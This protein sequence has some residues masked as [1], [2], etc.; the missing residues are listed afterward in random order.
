[1]I[2]SVLKSLFC[3]FQFYTDLVHIYYFFFFNFVGSLELENPYKNLKCI[4]RNDNLKI[5]LGKFKHT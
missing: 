5:K 2:N 1:M 4:N 3:A